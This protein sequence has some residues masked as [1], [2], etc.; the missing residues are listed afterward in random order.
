MAHGKSPPN[1]PA[2]RKDGPFMISQKSK[3]AKHIIAVLI[4]S[5]ILSSCTS[6]RVLRS[7]YLSDTEQSRLYIAKVL[8]KGDRV[9]IITTD[10]RKLAFKV[11]AITSK[12]VI[13]EKQEVLFSEIVT[14]EKRKFNFMR[15]VALVGAMAG[16]VVFLWYIWLFEELSSASE[17]NGVD[18]SLIN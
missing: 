14:M 6:S 2:N 5:L 18:Q 4:T 10:G 3:I 13:G 16:I 15:T 7:E 12:A 8:N 17:T 9:K 11:R 1:Y